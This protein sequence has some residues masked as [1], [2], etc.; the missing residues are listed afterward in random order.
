MVL[1]AEGECLAQW[2]MHETQ[3]GSIGLSLSHSQKIIAANWNG[4]ASASWSH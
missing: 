2:P 3:I 4:L 1:T